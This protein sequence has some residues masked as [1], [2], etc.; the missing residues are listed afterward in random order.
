ME[1]K[2]I[3][4][5]F[6]ALAPFW[7]DEMI[8]NDDII[9]QILDNANV[10]SGKD[11]LDVACGTGVLFHDYIKRDVKSVTAIDIS[12]EMVKIAQGKARSLPIDV[13]CGDVEEYDFSKAFDCIVIYNAFPHFPEPERLIATLS[14]KLRRGGTLT[15]AHGMSRKAIDAH[16]SG[17]AR[18]VSN[19][20]MEADVLAS[21]FEKY[22]NVKCIMSDDYIYQV[23]GTVQDGAIV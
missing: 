20:L 13:I 14:K 10:T 5:F 16:H 17:S 4:D 2:D 18:H 7:D 3:I 8:K 1:K 23:V 12:S 22:T 21:I 11:I 9:T 6:D 15:V 19:G